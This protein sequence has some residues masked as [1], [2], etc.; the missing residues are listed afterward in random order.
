MTRHWPWEVSL[1]M[2]NE[3][4]CGGALIDPSWVVTAAHCIQAPKSTQ[5]CLAPPS[6]SP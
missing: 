4:V 3:H 6:C 1:R 2:E 5:W